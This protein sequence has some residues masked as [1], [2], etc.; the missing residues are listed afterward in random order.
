MKARIIL[1]SL[2][3]GLSG[4]IL[5]LVFLSSIGLAA[6]GETPRLIAAL[7][8]T[9]AE[10]PP[11]F[12]GDFVFVPGSAVAVENRHI[13]AL[14]ENPNNGFYAIAI[15]SAKCDRGSCAPME[16]ISY[17]IVDSQGQ[18]LALANGHEAERNGIPEQRV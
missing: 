6:G 18:T 3:L 1:R 13:L 11:T 10:A 12:L 5:S 14:Y 15:F 9:K 2:S 16:L 17:S 4:L 7:N 8:E